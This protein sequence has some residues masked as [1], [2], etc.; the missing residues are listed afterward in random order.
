MNIQRG[1]NQDTTGGIVSDLERS[2]MVLVARLTE[3]QVLVE[4]TEATGMVAGT[5]KE[6]YT[7]IIAME[8]DTFKGNAQRIRFD[9]IS[10]AS[11]INFLQIGYIY[12]YILFILMLVFML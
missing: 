3:M 2:E 4:I 5:D 7:V 10:F 8:L 9:T 11:D 12:M 6:K 1:G